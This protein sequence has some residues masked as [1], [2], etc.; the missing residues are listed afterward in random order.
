[1]ID[2]RSIKDYLPIEGK[3]TRLGVFTRENITDAY[4]AWLNNP[5]VTQYSNQRFRRHTLQTSLDYL[6]TFNNSENLFLAVLSKGDEEFIGTMT[7][8]LSSVH[9]TADMGI[10]IGDTRYWGKGIGSDAWL[11]MLTFLLD[12][13]KVRK[14]TGGTLGCNLSMQRIMLKSGMK[15]DGTR[16]AQ[17]LVDH[18]VQ[19]ILYFAKFC[20]A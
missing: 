14:A 6:E 15:P 17:E 4:L 16:I 7:V 5:A 2:P 20:G 3:I 19:D 8:F 1:M 18:H 12:K 13:V 10:M 9:E 11:T